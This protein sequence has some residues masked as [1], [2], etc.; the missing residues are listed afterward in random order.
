MNTL[1]PILARSPIRAQ[2]PSDMRYY[3]L[4]ENHYDALTPGRHQYISNSERQN[5]RQDYKYFDYY[6]NDLGFRDVYPSQNNPNVM[7][8][9]G[10]SLTFG[11][12][13]DTPDNFP[14][15]I[16]QHYGTECLNMGISGSTAKRVALTFAAAAKIWRMRLAVVVLPAWTRAL[17]ID[18]RGCFKN[19]HLNFKSDDRLREQ[20]LKIINDRHL[21]YETRDAIEQI[22]TNAWLRQI[23]LVITSWETL[24]HD[25]IR[26][27]TNSTAPIYQLWNLNAPHDP[28][29]YARDNSH[30]G[31][32][33]VNRFKDQLIHH[34]DTHK[35]LRPLP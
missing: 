5:S 21:L 26:E 18:E 29:E 10:C 6:I 33:L 28:D 31:P 23:P 20:Y 24:T 32:K 22:Q 9:F 14:H 8:F 11:E 35:L 2:T 34:I 13:L 25:L 16:S 27:L 17:H 30:P 12:G 19:L 15:K 4:A 1:D 3:G 7:G